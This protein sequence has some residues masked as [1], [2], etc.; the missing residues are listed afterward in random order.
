MADYAKHYVRVNVD[1]GSMPVVY[2]HQ[3]DTWRKIYCAV[4]ENRERI[5]LSGISTKFSAVLPN[6]HGGYFVQ[7]NK[8]GTIE[9]NYFVCDLSQLNINGHGVGFITLVIRNASDTTLTYRPVNIKLVVEKSADGADVIANA[10]D[11][12]DEMQTVTEDWLTENIDNIVADYIDDRIGNIRKISK[13]VDF[14]YQDI[15]DLATDMGH[16]YIAA[17]TTITSGGMYNLYYFQLADFDVEY[18]DLYGYVDSLKAI[19]FYSGVPDDSAYITSYRWDTGTDIGTDKKRFY[20]GDI[21]EGATYIALVNCTSKGTGYQFL[22]YRNGVIPAIYDRLSHFDDV[23]ADIATLQSE[24]SNLFETL[25]ADDATFSFGGYIDASGKFHV[26][27]AKWISYAFDATYISKI[28][29]VTAFT[30][31]STFFNINFYNNIATDRETLV[32]ENFISSVPRSGSTDRLQ[33]YSNISLP[34]GCKTVVITHCFGDSPNGMG[35]LTIN[36]NRL[37]YNNAIA[38]NAAEIENLYTIV[39]GKSTNTFTI[40]ENIWNAND[41]TFVDDELWLA[42]TIGSEDGCEIRR[43][44]IIDGV[45]TQ[46]GRPIYTDFGHWNTVDYNPDNDCLVFGNGAND[47][48]TEGNWF[49]VIPHPKELSGTVSIDDVGLRYYVDIGYKVQAVW[50]DSNLGNNNIVILYAN[51]CTT[52]V[53]VLLTK[54]SNGDFDGNYI[55]LDSHTNEGSSSEFGSGGGDYWGGDVYIGNGGYHGYAKLNMTDYSL[56]RID[57]PFYLD[58]GTVLRGSTQGMYIDKN[59]MWM[60]INTAQGQDTSVTNALIQYYR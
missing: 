18:V 47:F 33:E 41:F 38:K 52:I 32:E 35:D 34:D 15:T 23:D 43:Y 16:Y 14:L 48:D 1:G 56:T 3:N 9:N 25:D 37:K 39:R 7:T 24:T 27:A 49:A 6:A 50:G 2:V 19:A 20:I 28:V 21:P 30:N 29:S 51:N 31:S 5:Q 58:D 42:K 10:S 36:I 40:Y 26:S 55:V 54:D 8:Q 45:I 12:P 59:Y 13:R 4:Y 11:F 44:K 46:Q 17:N 60:F 53:K 22:G 57:M